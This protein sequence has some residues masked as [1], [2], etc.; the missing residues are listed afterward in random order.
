M[1]QQTI[2]LLWEVYIEII[3]G[4]FNYRYWIDNVKVI[5]LIIACLMNWKCTYNMSM[6][7]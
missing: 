5:K 2:A 3:G 6:P 1:P 4:Q 7:K